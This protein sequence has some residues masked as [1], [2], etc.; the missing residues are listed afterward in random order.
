LKGVRE[1][2]CNTA[3]GPG[4]RKKMGDEGWIGSVA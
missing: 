1:F 3:I 2:M 4:R